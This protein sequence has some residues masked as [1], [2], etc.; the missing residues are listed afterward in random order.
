MDAIGTV[1]TSVIKNN[2]KFD[3][4]MAQVMTA[5]VALVRG[6]SAAV[7]AGFSHKIDRK[8]I[9]LRF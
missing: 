7:G 1:L 3:R 5:I 9:M 4:Q 8:K 6:I 2:L